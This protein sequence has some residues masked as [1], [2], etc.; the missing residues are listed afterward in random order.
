MTIAIPELDLF[1]ADAWRMDN[2]NRNRFDT[3]FICRWIKM[4]EPELALVSEDYKR[5]VRFDDCGTKDRYRAEQRIKFA[6][7]IITNWRALEPDTQLAFH[8]GEIVPSALYNQ[9]LREGKGFGR[10]R[11]G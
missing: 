9:L 3:L 6:R 11:R 4:S 8:N 5:R 2:A 10:R 7:A 1:D